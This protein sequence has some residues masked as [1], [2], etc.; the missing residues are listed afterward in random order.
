MKT[1]S[2]VEE[3]VPW[4]NENPGYRLARHGR[5]IHAYMI[6]FALFTPFF[7]G[8]T[9]FSI[10][11]LIPFL[12]VDL[13]PVWLEGIYFMLVRFLSSAVAA[14]PITL[15]MAF[16]LSRTSQ[17]PG[18]KLTGIHVVRMRD[19]QERLGIVRALVRQMFGLALGFWWFQRLQ[20]KDRRS[21]QDTIAGTI[22]VEVD[23]KVIRL[24]KASVSSKSSSVSRNN[25]VT[26]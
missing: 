17:T 23:Q 14:T 6:D 13:N 1:G 8:G 11:L 22:V 21:M 12:S 9:I 16:M 25:P 10:D 3:S 5:R 4:L 26:R 15:L 2:H 7:W 20:S 24:S 19:P 18:K